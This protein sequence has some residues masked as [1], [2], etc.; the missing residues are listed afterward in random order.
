VFDKTT[1]LEEFLAYV[2]ACGTKH[3]S[4]DEARASR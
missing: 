4:M 2:Q 3:R 1:Q